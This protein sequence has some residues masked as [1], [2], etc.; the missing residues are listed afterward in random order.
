[1]NKPKSR[2]E[3]IAEIKALHDSWSAITEPIGDL[4]MMGLPDASW[5]VVIHQEN[6]VLTLTNLM[7]R[8]DIIDMLF[9]AAH[10]IE[11]SEGGY[12]ETHNAPSTH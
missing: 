11:D 12:E 9:R 2:S 3:R 4:L 7:R 10:T 8:E 5:C 6:G 1:M